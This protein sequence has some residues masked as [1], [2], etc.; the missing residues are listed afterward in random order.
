VATQDPRYE[1]GLVVED[2]APRAARYV[3]TLRQE[4]VRVARACGQP[5]PAWIDTSQVEVLADPRSSISLLDLA[6][7][8]SSSWG[9]PN[10]DQRAVLAAEWPPM[11][12]F[13][14]DDHPRPE[15]GRSE[16]PPTGRQRPGG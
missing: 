11:A 12:G 5:H 1:R 15:H 10:A 4:L 14:I 16:A 9:R 8:H 2:K 6:G 7:Y 3:A 13:A